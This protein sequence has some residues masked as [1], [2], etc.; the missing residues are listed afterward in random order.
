MAPES[1]GVSLILPRAEAARLSEALER[2]VT[3]EERAEAVRDAVERCGGR[4]RVG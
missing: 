3:P 1:E 4:W 2:L